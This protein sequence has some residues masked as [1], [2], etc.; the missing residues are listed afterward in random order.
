[1]SVSDGGFALL[2]ADND[3]NAGYLLK[4]F[5]ENGNLINTFKLSGQVSDVELS[6][7]YAYVLFDT[8]IRRIDVLF[9]TIS[10]VDFSEEGAIL[11]PFSDGS[12]MACT[13]TVAYYISFN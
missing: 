7:N 2:F 8:E 3:V 4:V 13:D 11:M 10:S 5:G 12:L 6:G 9:G 1:M